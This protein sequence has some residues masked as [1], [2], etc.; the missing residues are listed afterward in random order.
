M[1]AAIHLKELPDG[2]VRHD[3]IAINHNYHG[4]G[5][6]LPS[7]APATG[8]GGSGG[9]SAQHGDFEFAGY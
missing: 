2:S 4:G 9:S 7:P 1:H 6:G 8:N 3:E 5:P